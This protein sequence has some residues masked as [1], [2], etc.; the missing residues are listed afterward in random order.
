MGA[1]TSS[2]K[3][4]YDAE[5]KFQHIL[6]KNNGSRDIIFR[7]ITGPDYGIDGII[8]IFEDEN[9]TGKIGFIQIKGQELKI[10]P[11]KRWPNFVSCPRVSKANLMYLKQKRIP[12]IL[13]Y[14]SLSENGFYYK[15][16]EASDIDRKIK[17]SNTIRIDIENYIE[18]NVEDFVNRINSFYNKNVK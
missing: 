17:D 11:L 4:A 18:N 2:Q 13:V 12:I 1:Y 15:I 10:Q 9:P 7:K 8:E 6:C 3:I 16:L 14:I 5:V